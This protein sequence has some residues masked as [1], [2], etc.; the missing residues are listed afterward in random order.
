MLRKIITI[1]AIGLPLLYA[2]GGSGDCK[3]KDKK[4]F[5]TED[6]AAIYKVFLADKSG[7]NMIL[8]KIDGT[9][10]VNGEFPARTD[11][12][13]V[14]LETLK[15][16]E[17]KANVP[18]TAVENTLKS[19]SV[20]H[21]KV[22]LYEKG[23]KKPFKVFYVG[24]TTQDQYGTYMLLECAT[25]PYICYVPGFRGYLTPRFTPMPDEWRSRELFNYGSPDQIQSVRMEYK[26][27][28][29]QSFELRFNGKSSFTLVSLADGQEKSGFDTLR[30]KE[31]LRRFKNLGFERYT[32]S[33]QAHIDSLKAKYELYSITVTE[34]NGQRKNI[35]LFQYPL[36]PGS[37]DVIG[38][39]V[40][41]DQDKMFGLIDEKNFVVAQ[42]FTFDGITVPLSWFF[43]KG[44]IPVPRN[45]Y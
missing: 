32:Q 26:R 18:K 34:S 30:A 44:E 10:M 28:P 9:W 25:V 17:V 7:N 36:P 40:E 2:C 24:G 43:E 3:P 14:L 22:E 38:N 4:D 19:L 33:D 45:D 6:T 8:E 42:Y 21:H 39:P 23:A 29:S 15:R 37:E 13:A 5:K 16:V 20:S 41:I 11:L 27:D 12:M 1:V 35:R 31:F